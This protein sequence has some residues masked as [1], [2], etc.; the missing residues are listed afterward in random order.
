[1]QDPYY[2]V[3]PSETLISVFFQP[4][5]RSVNVV[6]NILEREREKVIVFQPV[7]N[8]YSL[9][10]V[11]GVDVGGGGGDVLLCAAL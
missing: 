5:D 11:G 7:K 1:M 2:R 3:C 9:T 8:L 10:D 6:Q 4:V